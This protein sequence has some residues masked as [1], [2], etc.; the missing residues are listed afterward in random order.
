MSARLIYGIALCLGLF[1]LLEPALD[2]QVVHDACAPSGL[3][4]TATVAHVF[5]Y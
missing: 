3:P 5:G 2:Y 4:C 1:G